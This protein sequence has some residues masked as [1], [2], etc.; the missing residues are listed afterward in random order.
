MRYWR[1]GLIIMVLAALELAALPMWRPLA[2]AAAFASGA[3]LR[4]A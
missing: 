4:D 1:F 3:R 2:G